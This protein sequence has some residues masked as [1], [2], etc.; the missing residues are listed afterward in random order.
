MFGIGKPPLLGRHRSPQRDPQAG[1]HDNVFGSLYPG[2]VGVSD[3]GRKGFTGGAVQAQRFVRPTAAPM[4]NDREALTAPMA[5]NARR[6]L[7]RGRGRA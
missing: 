5:G 7:N 6:T 3:T 2:A 4:P 1:I